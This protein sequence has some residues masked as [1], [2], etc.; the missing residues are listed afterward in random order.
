[1][2]E[3]DRDAF[4]MMHGDRPTEQALADVVRAVVQHRLHD[5]TGHPLGRLAQERL[6]RMR[7]TEQPSLVGASQFDLA[8]PPLPRPNLKDPV[9]C[10]A[11]AVIDG[12]RTAVVCTTGVDLDAVPYAVDT[13]LALGIEP[14]ILAM[15]Q[16]D[17]LDVQ[18]LLAAAALPPITIVPVD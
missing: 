2:G 15:P 5:T 9:P 14:C 17:A 6:L 1:V 4:Q 16:R 13:R 3:H 12:V 10:V 18:R 8:G 11:V 7:L